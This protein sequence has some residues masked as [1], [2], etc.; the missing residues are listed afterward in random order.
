MTM[1]LPD[2]ADRG[3][4]IAIRPALH[5]HE[6]LEIGTGTTFGCRDTTTEGALV[7]RAKPTGIGRR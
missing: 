3:G 7:K 4:R 2:T 6:S 5:P 1:K